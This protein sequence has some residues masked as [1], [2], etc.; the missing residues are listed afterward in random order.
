MVSNTARPIFVVAGVGSGAGTG[1]AAAKLFAKEGYNVALIAR[2]ADHLKKTSD[3]INAAGGEAAPF[4]I[5]AYDP[6]SLNSAFNSI[7]SRW[8]ESQLRSA[9]WNVGHGIWKPFLH[10][11]DEEVREMLDTTVRASFAFSRLVINKFK[12]NDINEAGKRGTLIFQGATAALR[13]NSTTS[14]FAAG[15]FGTR[16]LSQSLNK[17]FGKDNIHVAHSVIDGVILTDRSREW[18]EDT[19]WEANEDARL[20]PGS[21]AKS[22]LYLTNQ[23]RSAWTWELDLRPA[24]ETW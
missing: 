7:A 10:V 12:K 15:K 20:N 11:T 22:Y 23:D 17:E 6:A 8:P 14:I 5:D 2:N 16:A 3:E 13:G 4:P 1:A 9:L 21:I 24:H 19:S 18:R